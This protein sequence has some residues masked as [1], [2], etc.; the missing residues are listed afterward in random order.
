MS[1]VEKKKKKNLWEVGKKEEAAVFTGE[2]FGCSGRTKT[3]KG[4][5]TVGRR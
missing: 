3:S 1:L 5:K 2:A 4:P